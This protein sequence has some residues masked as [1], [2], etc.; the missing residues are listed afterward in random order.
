VQRKLSRT[1]CRRDLSQGLERPIT[2]SR[3]MTRSARLRMDRIGRY[4]GCGCGFSQYLVVALIIT[5]EG[6]KRGDGVFSF[7]E[8]NELRDA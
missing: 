2:T 5:G 3:R 1:S 4:E 7:R 6:E 8:D